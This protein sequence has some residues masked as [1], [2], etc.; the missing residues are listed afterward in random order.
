V[1]GL[2]ELWIPDMDSKTDAIGQRHQSPRDAAAGKLVKDFG[3]T[4]SPDGVPRT[5]LV[6]VYD[7]VTGNMSKVQLDWARSDGTRRWLAAEAAHFTNSNW[8]FHNVVEFRENPRQKEGL[9]PTLR[10]NL[11]TLPELT[12]T[13]DEIRSAVKI[14]QR[15]KSRKARGVDLPVVEILD[16]L[17]LH[18]R[19]AR[20]ERNWIY[21]KLHG[22][23]A[24]PWKCFVVV[25]IALPF[26]AVSGRRNVFAGVAGSIAICFAYLVLQQ[27]AMAFGVSGFLPGW[28][29]GWL[30]N[31]V[32]A[33]LGLWLTARMR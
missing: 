13:P 20:D 4:C 25:L 15:L 17:R 16:Y 19:P 26:G 28:L 6:G 29:A 30:P 7:P 9:A 18:P 23:L 21:T 1:L 32:F 14:S 24:E 22:R 3:F 31:L 2:N 8:T 33:A 27:L 5:W 11:L 10:T 12:E